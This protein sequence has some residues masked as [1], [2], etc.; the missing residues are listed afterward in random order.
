MAPLSR[1]PT[2]DNLRAII[3][4]RPLGMAR[5]ATSRRSELLKRTLVEQAR[6]KLDDRWWSMK[7]TGTF[8]PGPK[9][10]VKS[11][12]FL[13]LARESLKNM[14][15]VRFSHTRIQGD[16]LLPSY[17]IF[18]SYLRFTFVHDMIC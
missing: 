11:R 16:Y 2:G 4:R 1:T 17:D 8:F 10:F 13:A 7:A 5:T 15:F 12:R 9:P 18:D 6:E 14:V 3:A